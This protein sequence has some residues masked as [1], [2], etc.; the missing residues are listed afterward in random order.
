MPKIAKCATTVPQRVWL[1]PLAT[2]NGKA[3]KIV[4]SISVKLIETVENQSQ[5]LLNKRAKVSALLEDNDIVSLPFLQNDL[6]KFIRA[7]DLFD[8]VFKEYLCKIL[9]EIRG[10]G[11]D[12]G[13]LS[14]LLQLLAA[15]PLAQIDEFTE[16]LYKEASLLK[17][18]IE[19]LQKS[20]IVLDNNIVAWESYFTETV[21]KVICLSI[22]PFPRGNFL[23]I[24]NE[25]INS[26]QS[27]TNLPPRTLIWFENKKFDSLHLMF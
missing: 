17:T 14:K 1:Y 19:K 15:S 23:I 6:E 22:D 10:A 27:E 3:A 2:L 4:Q 20:G 21:K 7:I 13:E 25:F 16:L 8:I 5:K 18:Y 24:L 26:F 11:K 9:P 12:Q